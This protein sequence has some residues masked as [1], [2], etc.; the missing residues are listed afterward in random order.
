MA[1]NLMAPKSDKKTV[2]LAE[3]V[4]AKLQKKGKK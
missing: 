2:A 1:I 3:R 4:L